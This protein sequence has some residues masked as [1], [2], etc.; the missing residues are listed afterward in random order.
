MS[1][2]IYGRLTGAS[3]CGDNGQCSCAFTGLNVF[4]A[5]R[6]PAWP[7]DYKAD[8]AMSYIADIGSLEEDKVPLMRFGSVDAC[9]EK[10]PEQCGFAA[11]QASKA[12]IEFCKKLLPTD[13][14]LYLRV[15]EEMFLP[16]DENCKPI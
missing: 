9:E 1:V 4:T 6:D 16:L 12:N 15:L 7:M 5:H 11:S 14:P 2:N 8:L 13:K 10:C 3:F